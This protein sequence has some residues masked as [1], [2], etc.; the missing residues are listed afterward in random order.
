M[1]GHV[2]IL[3]SEVFLVISGDTLV[4]LFVLFSALMAQMLL[5]SAIGNVI[6]RTINLQKSGYH[7]HASVWL[8]P[9]GYHMLLS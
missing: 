5:S 1:A 9:Q 7:V 3:K 6:S 4:L 2:F 8:Q